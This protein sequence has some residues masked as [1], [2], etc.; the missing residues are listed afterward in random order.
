MDYKKQYEV[1]PDDYIGLLVTPKLVLEYV[2][3]YSDGDS[4][5]KKLIEYFENEVKQN[6]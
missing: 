6:E 3:K 2:K 5:D 1:Y 4:I